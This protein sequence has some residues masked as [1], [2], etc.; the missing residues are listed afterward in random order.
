VL[1]ERASEIFELSGESP[2]MLLVANLREALREP[3]DWTGFRDGDGDMLKLLTQ[4][5]SSLPGVTHVDYSARVQTVDLERNPSL[6]KLMTKFNE[7]TGC[8]VLINTSFNVRGEPIV[9]SPDDAIRCFLNT[10]IELLSIGP[11]LALKRE[12]SSELR[13]REGMVQHEPD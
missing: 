13:S 7:I 6:H 5:R 11:H 1:A 3:V 8:P 10:G 4:K 12:Q 2:Y 9:C